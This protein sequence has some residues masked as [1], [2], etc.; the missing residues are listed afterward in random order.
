MPRGR[1][2]SLALAFLLV[3]TPFAVAQRDVAEQPCQ[4]ATPPRGVPGLREGSGLAISRRSPG[5]LFAVNDSGAPEIH[6]LNLDGTPR[7]RVAVSDAA[8]TDWEDL[9]SGPCPDGS[10]LY[11]SDIGDNNSVRRSITLYRFPEPRDGER[12]ASAVRFDAVYPD[13]PHNAEAVFTGPEGRLFLLTKEARGATLYAFPDRLEA[14]ALNRLDRLFALDF[15]EGRTRLERITDAETS[16]D[17]SMVVVRN[18][19]TLFLV[20][21]DALLAGR[22]SETVTFSLRRLGEPQGEGVAIGTDGD[23]F[24]IGEGRRRGA[25]GT[26]ARLTCMAGLPRLH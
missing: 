26:F 13:G 19:D 8:V 22:L 3:H 18:N 4:I 9:T 2:G 12:Q 16:A 21:T 11:I 23:V 17:G 20:P 10:C 5:R 15:G 14:G 1:A 6:V 7:G 25:L 24:L